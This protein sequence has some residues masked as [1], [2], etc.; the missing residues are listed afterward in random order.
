M[1]KLSLNILTSLSTFISLLTLF[2][3][4]GRRKMPPLMRS[5]VPLRNFLLAN[6]I[7]SNAETRADNR[8]PT[9]GG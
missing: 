9:T 4:T 3:V 2:L 1:L 7:R 5:F 6:Y 8:G